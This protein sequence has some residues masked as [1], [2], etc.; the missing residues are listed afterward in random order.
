MIKTDLTLP[1]MLK[2]VQNAKEANVHLRLGE[3]ER[4]RFNS[5]ITILDKVRQDKLITTEIRN[6]RLSFVDS[7]LTPIERKYQIPS[8]VA[9]A[10]ML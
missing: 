5:A 9:T 8:T 7:I 1:G 10:T 4:A 3:L 6:V 2:R